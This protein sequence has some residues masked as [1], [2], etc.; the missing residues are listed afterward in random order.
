M[1]D[2]KTQEQ[3]T[4]L[5]Q[6]LLKR[7]TFTPFPKDG[8]W[9]FGVGNA[10]NDPNETTGAST[11]STRILPHETSSTA[12]PGQQNRKHP[13]EIIPACRCLLPPTTTRDGSTG[14]PNLVTV[15][16]HEEFGFGKCTNADSG[17]RVAVLFHNVT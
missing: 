7:H 14:P 12:Q 10:F 5:F 15:Q 1:S 9:S 8:S 17:S 6:R 11:L 3:E 4:Q 2:E 16:A 13:E